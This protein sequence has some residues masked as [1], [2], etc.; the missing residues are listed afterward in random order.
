MVRGIIEEHLRYGST[1]RLAAEV[2]TEIGRPV[3]RLTDTVTNYGDTPKGWQ[4]LYHVNCGPPLLGPGSRF[5]APARTVTPRD[6]RAA[7]G[8]ISL[9]NSYEGPHGNEYTE[10]VFLME[11]DADAMGATR[12]MLHNRDKSK[13]VTLSFNKTQLPYF[14]LWKNEVSTHAG[15]VT[16]LEPATSYP[17]DRTTE[18]AAGRVP[19]LAPGESRCMDIMIAVLTSV[20]SIA[21]EEETILKLVH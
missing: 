5:V 3:I 7:E 9:W 20:D 18:R 16:G 17:Y 10:Q 21:A 19:V 4:A 2:S 15:Y 11:L 14:A 8:D 13:A 1:L 12:V 6:A